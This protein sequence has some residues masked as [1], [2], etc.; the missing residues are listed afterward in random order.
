[1]LLPAHGTAGF[2]ARAAWLALIPGLL[3]L[4]RF[5]H[6]H[7]RDQLRTLV[8]DARRRVAAFRGRHGEVEAYAEDPLRD[9]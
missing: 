2:L 9:L 6:P 5:F 3:V 1:L 7:E 4:T 8:L